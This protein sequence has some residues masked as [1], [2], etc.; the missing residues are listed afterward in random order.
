MLK[1]AFSVY[2]KSSYNKKIKDI[3]LTLLE[4]LNWSGI[5]MIE[6][7][8]DEVDK[9]YYLIEVNPRLWGSFMLS[10]FCGARFLENYIEITSNKG[11]PSSV[12]EKSSAIQRDL[13]IRW[14]FPWDFFLLITTKINL[15]DFFCT[16]TIRDCYVGFTNS[17]LLRSFLFIL[18][19]IT[20]AE[21]SIK[22]VSKILRG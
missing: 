19:S 18:F 11:N 8:Y 17:S 13:G 5:A 2:S 7:L 9:K 16:D 4:K 22:F 20:K 14:I 10:D 1:G 3:G 21:N 15:K 6:F 12:H